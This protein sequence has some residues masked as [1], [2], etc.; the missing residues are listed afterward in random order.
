M[1]ETGDTAYP[2]EEF[3]RDK[4]EGNRSLKDIDP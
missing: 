4:Y 1:L 2:N 3:S